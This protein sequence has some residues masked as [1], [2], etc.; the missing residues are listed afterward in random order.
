[1]FLLVQGWSMDV[2]TSVWMDTKGFSDAMMACWKWWWVYDKVENGPWS[3]DVASDIINMI[4]PILSYV[5][6]WTLRWSDVQMIRW[7]DD[8]MI[9]ST[10]SSLT[11]DLENSAAGDTCTLCRTPCLL[12]M[13]LSSDSISALR[14]SDPLT[15]CFSRLLASCESVFRLIVV[16]L[17]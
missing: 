4:N 13:I 6:P 17:V 3:D 2:G 14:I 11:P 15:H 10:L 5:R 9:K 8:Q 16:R 1:M 12:L 7:S